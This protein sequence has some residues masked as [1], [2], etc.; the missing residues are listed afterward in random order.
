MTRLSRRNKGCNSRDKSANMLK[1]Y[2]AG[3]GISGV[4]PSKH[5]T[6]LCK[7]KKEEIKEGTYIVTLRLFRE[8][9]ERISE[10]M[11]YI[12]HAEYKHPE[13]LKLKR[14]CGQV[15]S[16]GYGDNRI[17]PEGYQSQ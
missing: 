14:Y 12:E 13:L 1:E 17:L 2:L 16:Y 8:L 10:F 11:G 4:R 9:S 3:Q 15:Y 7:K 5:R 6:K